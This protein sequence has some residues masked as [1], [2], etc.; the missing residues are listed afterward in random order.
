MARLPFF[1]TARDSPPAKRPFRR[2]HY[3]SVL[4]AELH[5]ILNKATS[6]DPVTDTKND[7]TSGFI[8]KLLFVTQMSACGAEFC[9]ST[10][11][12]VVFV[13]ESQ[14]PREGALSRT[15]CESR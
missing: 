3:T 14:T 1:P 4:S 15:V 13:V 9:C 12:A 10:S 11:V 5:P 7:A 6:E 2:P 8:V